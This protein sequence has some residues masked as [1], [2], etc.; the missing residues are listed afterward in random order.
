MTK[1]SAEQT[2]KTVQTFKQKIK[3]KRIRKMSK[4]EVMTNTNGTVANVVRYHGRDLVINN[5]VARDAVTKIVSAEQTAENAT[6]VIAQQVTRVMQ[7]KAYEQDFKSDT[8]FAETLGM[9]KSLVSQYKNAVSFFTVFDSE[10]KEYK[11]SVPEGITV[12]Q[13]YTLSSIPTEKKEDF[14]MQV[15]KKAYKTALINS[16][17]VSYSGEV[18]RIKAQSVALKLY[19]GEKIAKEESKIAE[20]LQ[21]YLENTDSHFIIINDAIKAN[22]VDAISRCALCLIAERMSVRQLKE[23]AK[24]FKTN[25]T[26]EPVVEEELETPEEKPETPEEKPETP[27]EK[28]E[29]PE[30]KPETSEEKQNVQ[31]VESTLD[32]GR[33][34][35]MCSKT[36]L[37][38]VVNELDTKTI[39][40]LKALL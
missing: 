11:L 2:L 37:A 34:L 33:L 10:T 13:A 14:Y 9:S 1:P 7:E 15:V 16:A 39:I 25:G 4:N 20:A 35:N 27:E 26:I 19:N 32:I 22:T 18:E 28:P 36:E 5:D 38:E 6:W 23:F 24:N 29:T 8:A 31:K 3:K 12:T 30:E 21:T 17:T 40:A